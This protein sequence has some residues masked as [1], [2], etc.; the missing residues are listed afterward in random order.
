M[1]AAMAEKKSYDKEERRYRVRLEGFS[2]EE[3]RPD[4]AVTAVD[5][6]M[7]PLHEAPVSADGEFQLPAEALK[8]A[9]RIVIGPRIEEG[10]TVDPRTVLRYRPAQ[11]QELLGATGGL[12]V[13]SRYWK[14]WRGYV[15]CVTGS[16]RRCRPIWDWYVDKLRVFNAAVGRLAASS[17]VSELAEGS[18]L[19]LREKPRRRASINS[20]RAALDVSRINITPLRPLRCQVVCN[21]TVE[22]YRRTCCCHREWLLADPRLPK[23]IRELEVLVRDLDQPVIGPW[24]PLP[25]PPPEF[26]LAQEVA[27]LPFLMEGALNQKTLNARQDLAAIRSLPAA[28]AAAYILARPYLWVCSCGRPTKVAQG[29]IQPNGTFSICWWEFPRLLRALCHDEYAYVVKQVINGV[30]VTIYNGLAADIW[31]DRTDDAELTTYSPLARACRDNGSRD[32]AYVYLEL[33]GDAEAWHLKTPDATGWDRVAAPAFNDGLV[34]PSGDPGSSAPY[35]RPWGGTLKIYFKFSEG[36]RDVGAKYYR[37][38]VTAADASGNPVGPRTYIGDGLSWEKSVGAGVT[39][40][41]SLGPVPPATVGGQNYLYII[42]YDH[43]ADWD[44]DQYHAMLDTNR[45]AWN[46]PNVRHLLTLEVFDD[47]GRRL[48]PNGTPAT[49][50]PGPEIEAPFTYRRQFQDLG[51]SAN[52]PF[53][54]LTHMFWWDNRPVFADLETLRRD[55]L[56]YNAECQYLQGLSS[57]EF[58]VGYR[59]YHPNPLFHDSHTI[60]WY[61]GAGSTPEH[62]DT[63]TYSTVNVGKPPDPA[64]VSG[65]NTFGQMLRTNLDPSRLKCSFVVH[66]SVGVKT[67]DGENFLGY[68]NRYDEWAFSIEING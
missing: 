10:M 56:I 65:S 63:L 51:P 37:L 6:D 20:I 12:D 38:S 18:P 46:D 66:L 30:P 50:Q 41:V 53:G 49:G 35:D 26:S 28:E 68:L 21:G 4:F 7:K 11:F 27:K 62:Q 58:S 67:F 13:A 2:P 40:P 5:R 55:G 1:E 3:E 25:D 17:A 43:D 33:I 15:V 59:A 60:W 29:H 9:H 44:A 22:V 45:I 42:P 19:S 61:R 36:L 23:L 31:F 8:A 14:T 34:H 24:P 52:V 54:A 39:V 64:G 47:T 48:R 57:S 32:D 16:V